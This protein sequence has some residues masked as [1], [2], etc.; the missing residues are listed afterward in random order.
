M[1]SVVMAWQMAIYE[2]LRE[3]LP[4]TRVFLEGVP[5]NSPVP[6]DHTGLIKPFVVLWFGQ[7]TRSTTSDDDVVAGLCDEPSSG[8]LESQ[9]GNFAVESAAP[10]G[11]SL[12]QLEDALRVLLTGFSPAGQGP[13]IEDGAASIR[14]PLPI[15]I[16]DQIRFYKALFFRGDFSTT[17]MEAALRAAMPEA[18]RTH[19][20]QGHPY[21]EVNTVINGDGKRRCRTCINARARARRATAV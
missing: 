16:G 10:S 9:Q 1:A 20:P 6:H 2:R 4:N 12:L 8:V 15:G 19:C 13:L 7:L 18:E 17:P 14:D 21:D 11:L 5:E 3:S